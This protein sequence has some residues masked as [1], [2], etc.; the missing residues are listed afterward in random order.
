M[1]VLLESISD[2]KVNSTE[3]LIDRNEELLIP[4]AIFIRHT[5]SLIKLKFEDI[6]WLKGDGN[7]TTVVTRKAVYSVRNI[8][9]DFEN[10][11]PKN[12]F[13]RIHKSYMVRIDEIAEITI[14]EVKVGAD[15]VPIG[16]TY[17]QGLIG[18]IRRIESGND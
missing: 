7:Y 9:K 17:Y 10:T 2:T 8:L 15:L 12:E 3:L 4:D 14:R 16:R 11:L 5:G 6:L 1:K 18:G 13:L